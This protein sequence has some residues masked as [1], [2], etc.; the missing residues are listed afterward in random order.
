MKVLSRVYTKGGGFLDNN[1]SPRPA[2]VVVNNNS[3]QRQYFQEPHFK[4]IMRDTPIQAVY[5]F[6]QVDTALAHTR[7]RYLVTL[8]SRESAAI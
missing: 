3:V 1:V 8:H 4:K 7:R 5:M 6:D 2:V